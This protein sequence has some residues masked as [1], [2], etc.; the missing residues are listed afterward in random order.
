MQVKNGIADSV[1]VHFDTI[2][3]ELMRLDIQ[4]FD[5]RDTKS[6]AGEDG[7]T[8]MQED[9]N[10]ARGGPAPRKQLKAPKDKSSKE[11][12]ASGA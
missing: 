4:T 8:Q 6:R 11:Q 7:V 2:N 9:K 3:A 12:S 5:I 10:K 1:R